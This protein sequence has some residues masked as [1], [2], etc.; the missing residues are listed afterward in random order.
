M[1]NSY[2]L[3][4]VIWVDAEEVGEI[5][6][7]NLEDMLEAAALPCPI[8][9]SIGYLV[10]DSESHIS[11]IRAFFAEGSSSVEKIPKRFIEDL[12]VLREG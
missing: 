11:L 10:H 2:P 5:G 1:S 3:V 6:W 8:V 9:H 7:N 12:R 4:E